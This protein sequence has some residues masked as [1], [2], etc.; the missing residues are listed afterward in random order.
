MWPKD[1]QLIPNFSSAPTRVQR[2]PFVLSFMELLLLSLT[3]YKVKDQRS[4]SAKDAWDCPDSNTRVDVATLNRKKYAQF[5]S[6]YDSLEPLSPFQANTSRNGAAQI[7]TGTMPFF[8]QQCDSSFLLL[9]LLCYILKCKIVFRRLHVAPL[10]CPVPL[11]HF[12]FQKR[13]EKQCDKGWVACCFD[14]ITTFLFWLWH[15]SLIEIISIFS[16]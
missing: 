4:V 2:K 11:L 12:Y 10:Y 15:T 5:I 14:T 3:G 1:R 16:P 8:L 13:V 9:Q 7:S 6:F